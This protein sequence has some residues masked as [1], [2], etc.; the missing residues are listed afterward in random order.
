MS[1]AKPK[2]KVEPRSLEELES[3]MH[4]MASMSCKPAG[5]RP[6]IGDVIDENQTVKWNREEVERRRAEYD[7]RVKD[8]NTRKN[9]W[10]DSLEKELYERMVLDLDGFIPVEGAKIIFQRA[11]EEGHA[12]GVSE[13]FIYLRRHMEMFS[14]ISK[15]V[16]W[17]ERDA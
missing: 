9:Q 11:Y 16:G 5:T 7:Q 1:V 4:R 10:R 8:L 17:G 12:G 2:K 14:D 3:E 6:R 15:V 13:V